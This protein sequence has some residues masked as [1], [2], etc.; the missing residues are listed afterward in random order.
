MILLH[1]NF[2][3]VSV[4]FINN[5]SNHMTISSPLS[6]ACKERRNFLCRLQAFYYYSRYRFTTYR[7]Y[8]WWMHWH[9]GPGNGVVIPSCVMER[10]LFFFTI[11]LRVPA[12][13]SKSSCSMIALHRVKIWYAWNDSPTCLMPTRF[14]SLDQVQ[15]KRL[16]RRPS[17]TVSQCLHGCRLYR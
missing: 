2:L 17:P 9:L 3:E 7:Q 5:F 1:P 10:I 4:Q 8:V 15:C 12:S 13:L 14:C 6:A 16:D 11:I